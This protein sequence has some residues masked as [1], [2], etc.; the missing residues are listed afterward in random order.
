M[1]VYTEDEIIKRL[2]KFLESGSKWETLYNEDFINYKGETSDRPYSEII[3]EWLL[4]GKLKYLQSIEEIHRGSKGKHYNEHD[5]E[6]PEINGEGRDEEDLAKIMFTRSTENNK[7]YDF[8]K[9]IDFQTPIKD[10]RDRKAGKIDLLAEQEDTIRFIELKRKGSDETLLRCILEIYT[11]Y[12]QVEH[13]YLLKDF[14][15]PENTKIIPTVLVF[16]DSEAWRNYEDKNKYP[17]THE[18]REKLKVEVKDLP[19]NMDELKE[20]YKNKK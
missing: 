9:I 12:K 14:K 17:K 3:S 11:Y 15:K 18:L 4:D 20:L 10:I 19:N 8:G 1:V 7:S 6:K 2:N 16:R 13:K 5:T